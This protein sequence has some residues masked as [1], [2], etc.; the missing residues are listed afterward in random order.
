MAA[1]SG[2]AGNERDDTGIVRL[3]IP[4][5]LAEQ[6]SGPCRKDDKD[7]AGRHGKG[8]RRAAFRH[9]EGKLGERIGGERR[10]NR[11][12]GIGRGH[13][14]GSNQRGDGDSR[15]MRVGETGTL[16]TSGDP[17]ALA[18]Q[19]REFASMSP[20][21]IL[22]MGKAARDWMT[23]EFTASHYR[24]RLLDLYWEMGVPV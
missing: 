10:E 13:L 23:R 4:R 6:H 12:D 15:C 21:R 1:P 18:A 8:E 14:P 2:V 22:R 24:R 17:E 19:L 5:L 3:A 20:E 11:D 9:R 7:Q 16:F